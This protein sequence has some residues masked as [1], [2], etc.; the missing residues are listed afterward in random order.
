VPIVVERSMYRNNRNE[1]FSAGHN[2][3]AVEAPAMRWFLAEGA[4]GGTFDEFVLIANPNANPA[5]L[6]VSYL[7][8]GKAPI[9]KTHVAP[10]LARLTLWV[11]QEAPELANAEVSVI[12][13]SQTPTPVVVERSMW[14]RASAAG[15]WVESHNSRGATSTAPRWLVADG[16]AGGTDDSSTYVLVANTSSTAAKVNF[17]LLT[18]QG[19][20]RSVQDTVSANGRYSLDVTAMF[21]EARDTR[22]SVLVE[23]VSGTAALV[24]ERASYSSTPTTPWASGTNALAMPVP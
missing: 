16:E 18:E 13:E 7:R 21:P 19:T 22:F 3:A 8:A 2:S 9:V 12:V 15:E 6:K 24:V 4:T 14:W 20:T 1:L 17:T 5:T 11:D 23:S 10:A